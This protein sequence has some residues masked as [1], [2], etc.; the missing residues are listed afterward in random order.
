[1]LAHCAWTPASAS[2]A[3][4]YAS[5]S[6]SILARVSLAQVSKQ[7]CQACDGLADFGAGVGLVAYSTSL[8]QVRFLDLNR[9]VQTFP[10]LAGV[11][12]LGQDAHDSYLLATAS[13]ENPH[14]LAR[15]SVVSAASP[16]E[17][18]Q[19]FVPHRKH[20]RHAAAPA[21]VFLA[22]THEHAACTFHTRVA[23]FE[24]GALLKSPPL[25]L[26]QDDACTCVAVRA[27]GDG[28][29]LVA[30]GG[31][32]GR[33]TLHRVHF[34]SRTRTK[35]VLHWHAAAVTALEF[36][37]DEHL[38]SGGSEGVLVLWRL[39]GGSMSRTFLP[40]LGAPIA[41]LLALPAHAPATSVVCL[42]KDGSLV[43][44]Q[45]PSLAIERRLRASLP[46]TPAVV[47]APTNGP[48][49]M[50][51]VALEN[52]RP[53]ALTIVDPRGLASERVVDVAGRN[54]VS[55]ADPEERWRV[56][57][58][59]FSANGE[60]CAVVL[61]AG[62]GLKARR[63]LRVLAREA[64]VLRAALALGEH[65][66]GLA[67][68][69]SGVAVADARGKLRVFA[70]AGGGGGEGGGAGEVWSCER[71]LDVHP[72][73]VSVVALSDSC[74]AAVLDGALVRV[75]DRA[76]GLV[77]ATHGQ[78]GVVVAGLAFTKRELFAWSRDRIC[79][80]LSQHSLCFDKGALVDACLAEGD[81]VGLL[82]QSEEDGLARVRTWDGEKRLSPPAPNVEAGPWAKLN[83][84]GP[85]TGWLLR[86]SDGQ[87]ALRGGKASSS[88][89]RE[90]AAGAAVLLALKDVV[91]QQHEPHAPSLERAGPLVQVE[92][93]KASNWCTGLPSHLLLSAPPATLYWPEAV[94]KPRRTAAPT[95]SVVAGVPEGN[96]KSRQ[97]GNPELPEDG[98][99][100]VEKDDVG[101]DAEIG[102]RLFG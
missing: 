71:V 2:P 92:R 94:K 51:A 24:L 18:Q 33:L 34:K 23:V 26:K 49:Q 43:H 28:A 15:L 10:R 78:A 7:T 95:P 36:L 89:P 98:A 72:L 83:W 37:D 30:T 42:L 85:E 13:P 16:G 38:V 76:S 63:E 21:S 81:G 19:C 87:L 9:P 55:N 86:T 47:V 57:Q 73:R 65:D 35:T 101:R 56:E 48:A 67:V 84:G 79:A 11:L 70:C 25:V 54:P 29:L 58:A 91:G 52:H 97:V 14:A 4:T 88:A 69:D 45:V 74:I 102:N 32:G 62:A 75:W 77:V 80:V 53:G 41:A 50:L 96:G 60:T 22:R 12:A 44:V 1:M 17:P 61:V 59:A 40:R 8:G 82:L 68:C 3:H 46:L 90:G 100:D 64:A 66:L 27:V 6:H 5:L 93:I 20:V 39:D 31:L 99:M